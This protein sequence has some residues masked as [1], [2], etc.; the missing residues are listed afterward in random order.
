MENACQSDLKTQEMTFLGVKIY[1]F[2][3]GKFP[4]PLNHAPAKQNARKDL[5][6]R[7]SCSMGNF[8]KHEDALVTIS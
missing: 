5:K 2:F 6:I 8:L 7:G 3:G 1:Q 4:P